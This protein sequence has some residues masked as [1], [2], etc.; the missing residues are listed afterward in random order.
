M[1]ICE[2][3][4]LPS[5]FFQK[6]EFQTLESVEKIV[7][8]VKK[9]G[10][11]AVKKYTQQFDNILLENFLLTENEI[12]NAYS[13]VDSETIEAIKFSA[14]NIVKLLCIFFYG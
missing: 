2:L 6:I 12:E 14:K 8:D 10:D 11:L 13:K 3:K 9:Q 4:N 7:D 1:K 5:E